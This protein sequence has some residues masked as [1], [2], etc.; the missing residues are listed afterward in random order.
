MDISELLSQPHHMNPGLAARYLEGF[1]AAM[2]SAGHT[3][4]TISGYVDSAIHF[5]GWAEASGLDYT[6]IHEQTIQAFGAH[7]CECPGGRRERR[8]SAGVL[9]SV[10]PSKSNL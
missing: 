6:D 8:V 5:G 10:R 3:R 1:A 7:R 2:A 4:F 9:L